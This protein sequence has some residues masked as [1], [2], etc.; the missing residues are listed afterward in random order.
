MISGF[1]RFYFLAGEDFSSELAWVWQSSWCHPRK[2]LSSTKFAILFSWSA[3]C[4]PLIH[5]HYQ[6]NGLWPW[7][8]E[9]RETWRNASPGKI[10]AWQGQ[11]GQRGDHS[12]LFLDWFLFCTTNISQI[13]L[14]WKL[15]NGNK[16]IQM[17]ISKAL[18]ECS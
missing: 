10:P 9:L 13:K 14:S 1:L 4:I 12:F 8:E 17:T 2:C 5:C 7:L 15:R 6:C 18:G 3:V 11:R 16:K